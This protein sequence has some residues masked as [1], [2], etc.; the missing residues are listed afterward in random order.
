MTSDITTWAAHVRGGVRSPPG[1]GVG[2]DERGGGEEGR[3]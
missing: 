2:V 3:G 1:I